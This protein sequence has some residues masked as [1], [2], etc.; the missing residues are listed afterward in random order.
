MDLRQVEKCFSN[1][2][3]KTNDGKMPSSSYLYLVPYN[4]PTSSIT[5]KS[6]LGTRSVTS[7]MYS[8]VMDPQPEPE[9]EQID[10]GVFFAFLHQFLMIFPNLATAS[11]VCK[12]MKNGGWG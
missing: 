7:T 10:L 9:N 8:I 4:I 2:E 11:S 12:I 3:K 6:N 1:F 5:R